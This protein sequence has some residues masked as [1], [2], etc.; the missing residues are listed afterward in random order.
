MI[1]HSLKSPN[2]QGGGP[3]AGAPI[4]SRDFLQPLAP[5]ALTPFSA[6]VLHEMAGRSWYNYYN[7]LGFDPTPKSRVVRSLHGRPYF[8][9]TL[10]AQLDAQ[11]AGIE[12][13]SLSIGGAARPLA[14]WEKPGLL[15]GLKLGGNARKAASVLQGLDR[16]IDAAE[17]Q[18]QAWLQRVQAMRW[19]QAEI[20]QIMEEIERTGAATLQLYVVA[21]HNLQSAYLRLLGLVNGGSPAQL[22]AALSTA[23][24][25]AGDLVELQIA[26]AVAD[27]AHSA[28]AAPEVLSFLAAGEYAAW[29]TQLAE[30]PFIAGLR[31]LLAAHGHR[32]AGE[33]ELRNP[34]WSENPAPLLAAVAAAAHANA[35]LSPPAGPD[36]GPL[37]SLIDAKRRKE[38]Q[39]L[40]QHVRQCLSL[41]SKALHVHAYTLA[42]TRVWALAA[43]REAMGDQRLLA[44]SDVFFYE[45]EEMKQMMTGEWNI[46]D[47]ENIRAT[48]S[49]RKQDYGTWQQTAAGDLLVGEN[50]AFANIPKGATGLP[51]A[52]GRCRGAVVAAGDPTGLA[53]VDGDKAVLAG[54]QVDAGWSAALPVT[55]AIVQAQGSPLDPVAAAAAALQIPLIYDVGERLAEVEAHAVAVVDG[56]QGTVTHGG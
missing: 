33:G 26:R 51:G 17:T 27:L 43:G 45:L 47:M 31:Q 30:G 49:Q 40:L 6:S 1:D 37:L 2:V 36:E 3:S 19:S 10:S 4:W 18:G 13:P 48:G 9:L 12:P 35:A 39:P 41:Q 16:E 56:S 11:Q 32:C 38:A 34:R 24:R 21:R 7:R 52:A 42:G 23:I 14:R 22:L 53:R 8:T 28:Q 29:E 46:S 25:P 54:V 5:G 55:A 15:A 20:L 50:E 44:E